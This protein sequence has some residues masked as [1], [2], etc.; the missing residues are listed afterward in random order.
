M[1]PIRRVSTPSLHIIINYPSPHFGTNT[2][3]RTWQDIIWC[4]GHTL[5]RR[6]E[7]RFISWGTPHC[8]PQ[9]WLTPELLETFL[10]THLPP[11]FS[12]CPTQPVGPARL[13]VRRTATAWWQ[14]DVVAQKMRYK[15]TF[16][17][18][19]TT[20]SPSRGGDV[21]VYVWHKPA[22]FAHSFVFFSCVYFCLFGSFTCIL[23]HKFSRQRSVFLLCSSG[24][25]SALLVLWFKHDFIQKRD[26]YDTKWVRSPKSINFYAQ[27][28]QKTIYLTKCL[29][30]WRANLTILVLST[31]YLSM[32]VSFS[33][34]IIP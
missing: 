18:I 27:W 25:I 24:F 8:P 11:R 5:T 4:K 16:L 23:F 1:Q 3:E 31:I 2:A 29:Q 30:Q 12:L 21:M 26:I 34:D 33:P 22:E 14:R 6:D 9:E 10:G 20:G 7:V 15:L 19:V 13:G 17:L 28:S 32:K